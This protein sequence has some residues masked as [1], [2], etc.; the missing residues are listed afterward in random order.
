MSSTL[1]DDL[2]IRR[3]IW[4]TVHVLMYCS[5]AF[6]QVVIWPGQPALLMVKLALLMTLSLHVYDL[7]TAGLRSLASEPIPAKISSGE[8]QPVRVEHTDLEQDFWYR[9]HDV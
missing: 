2:R 4:F 1:S 9:W 8:P 3:Q 7:Y 6:L 5:V